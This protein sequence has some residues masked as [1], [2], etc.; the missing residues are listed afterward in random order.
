MERAQELLAKP[1]VMPAVVGVSLLVL[2]IVA[3]LIV[4]RILKTSLVVAPAYNLTVTG[5]GSNAVIKA[6]ALP[7]LTNGTEFGYSF[8]IYQQ[9]GPG[10]ASPRLVLSH[11]DATGVQ[12]YLDATR[13]SLSMSVGGA[14][15]TPTVPYV[16]M[17]R[18]VHIVAVYANGTVTYFMDG[19]VANVAPIDT[20]TSFAGPSGNLTLGGGSNTPGMSGFLGWMGYVTYINFYPSPGL[21]KRLYRQGPTPTTGFFGMFGMSGYGVRSPVYKIN[22]TPTDN[23]QNNLM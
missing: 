11:P 6:T 9:P 22:S 1:H 4:Q 3:A 21:I 18:W 16:P 12:M 10:A 15:M 5:S 7:D 20:P 13:N 17:S 19:E 2:T 8:W 14:S 23:G